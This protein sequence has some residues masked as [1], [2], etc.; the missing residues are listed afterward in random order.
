MG[1]ILF[2]ISFHWFCWSYLKNHTDCIHLM[3]LLPKLVQRGWLAVNYPIL[4]KQV[5]S[6]V[7]LHAKWSRDLLGVAHSSWHSSIVTLYK[8][9]LASLSLCAEKWDGGNGWADYCIWR[10]EQLLAYLRSLKNGECLVA[11]LE[12]LDD[13]EYVVPVKWGPFKL[14][15]FGNKSPKLP[16]ENRWLNFSRPSAFTPGPYLLGPTPQRG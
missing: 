10:G 14:S 1:H 8:L 3:V 7:Q 4:A 16:L 13:A 2:L 9:S 5:W 12:M 11:R 6:L 15:M